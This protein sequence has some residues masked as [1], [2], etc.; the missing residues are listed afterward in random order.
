MDGRVTLL[1]DLLPSL[2]LGPINP[3]DPAGKALAGA[4]AAL[5]LEVCRC[6]MCLGHLARLCAQSASR[7]AKVNL[8][9]QACQMVQAQCG[10]A[11][12]LQCA[13]SVERD[14]ET[15]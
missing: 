10:E 5:D 2:E 8:A 15:S 13:K 9:L 4:F 14:G 12:A 6:D 1:A 7:T 3:D 11:P